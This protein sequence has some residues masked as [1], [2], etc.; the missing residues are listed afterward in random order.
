MDERD[1]DNKT[2]GMVVVE[3]SDSLSVEKCRGD[4]CYI[5]METNGFSNG[6]ITIRSEV[7]AEQLYFMLGQMLGK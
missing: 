3:N 2:Y 6:E 1:Y 7:M 4:W 5:K